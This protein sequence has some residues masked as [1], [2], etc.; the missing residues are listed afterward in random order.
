MS[1]AKILT[2][3]SHV[4][5]I[6]GSTKGRDQPI[7]LM[8]K[9]VEFVGTIDES[10]F[11]DKD[12][13]FLD[14]FCKA[15]EI[16]LAAAMKACL[17]KNKRK[18][19][20]ASIEEIFAEL[21]SGNYFA[22]APD[23]RHYLL[24]KRTF[25][26]NTNSHKSDFAHHMRCGD[27]LSEE[28]GRLNKTKFEKELMAMIDYIVKK[29]PKAKIVAIGNPP[30]QEA[31]GGAGASAK[32]V[33]HLFVNALIESKHVSEFCLVIPSRWFAGGKGL[34]EFRETV[35]KGNNVKS[36]THFS[37]SG[38]V[39]PTVDIDG[40]VCFFHW[41]NEHK[42]SPLFIA[43][44]KEHRL[45]L[46][47][48]DI[49]PDDP[50][51]FEILDTIRNNWS[52]GWVGE[53]AWTRKPFGLATDHFQKYRA[54]VKPF[55][56]S[57]KCIGRDKSIRFVEKAAITKNKEHVD[58]Y[59]VCIPRAYGGKKGQRRITLPAASVFIVEPGTILTE[60]YMVVGSFETSKQANAFAA[61]LRTDL[62]RYLLGLRKITQDIPSDRWNWVPAVPVNETWTDERLDH[63]FKLDKKHRTHI[64]KK[65][66]EWS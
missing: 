2:P 55:S 18:A 23:Q 63:L 10:R 39:F 64:S 13:V 20:I 24:S 60:T 38:D 8:E 33:Y 56:G 66:Q 44:G 14:P 15:G 36:I 32:P 21:Y 47:N 43:E 52:G 5:D 58:Q 65:L 16:L 53:T 51:A 34:D 48:Y 59:K 49:I 35:I 11:L 41:H 9:A 30:Y 6:L 27:Y 4:V 29:K 1:T 45:D 42:G 54:E 61:Y 46:R 31:D 3:D 40:G 22:L 17:I 28:D 12:T 50:G 26:G 7:M 62:A 37:R 25:Y 57:I 19:M